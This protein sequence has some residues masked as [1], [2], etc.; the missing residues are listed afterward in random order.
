MTHRRVS[1]HDWC[2]EVRC[3]LPAPTGRGAGRT[4]AKENQEKGDAMPASQARIERRKN[5]R[6]GAK[7]AAR[8]KTHDPRAKKF[9]F[10][11]QR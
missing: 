3:V 11:G 6:K 10:K 7:L 9:H 4:K 2:G 5:E 8:R 1:P